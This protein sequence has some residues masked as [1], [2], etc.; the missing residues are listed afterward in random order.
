M[1]LTQGE[2]MVMMSHLGKLLEAKLQI[3]GVI[4]KIF[5]VFCNKNLSNENEM[6]LTSN[7]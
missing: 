1:D 5:L 7:F 6:L 3:R 2:R 4:R